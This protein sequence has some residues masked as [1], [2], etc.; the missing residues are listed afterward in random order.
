M[1]DKNLHQKCTLSLF[2]LTDGKPSDNSFNDRNFPNNLMEVIKNKSKQFEN[3]LSLVMVGF[4][5]DE[6]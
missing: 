5:E 2:F 4:G 1:L 6:L 3:R